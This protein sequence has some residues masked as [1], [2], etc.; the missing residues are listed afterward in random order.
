MGMPQ[1]SP[2]NLTAPIATDFGRDGLKINWKKS[3]SRTVKPAS[4]GVHL[5]FVSDDGTYILVGLYNL[6]SAIA[7]H[8]SLHKTTNW[9]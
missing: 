6:F 5:E 4:H 9:T 2:F 8:R 7:H 1:Q 3:T